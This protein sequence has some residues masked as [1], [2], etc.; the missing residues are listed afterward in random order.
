MADESS[1]FELVSIYARF[2]N[3]CEVYEEFLEFIKII[4][5]IADPLLSTL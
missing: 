4:K 3:N 5:T 1:S 2:V